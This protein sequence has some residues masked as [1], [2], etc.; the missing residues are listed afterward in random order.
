LIGLART[1]KPTFTGSTLRTR[2][3]VQRQVAEAEAT[4]GAGRAF[5]YETFRESWDAALQSTE[6][7]LDRKSKMQLATSHANV[8]A[9]KAVE[10]VHDAAGASAI[11]N[12]YKFQRYFRDARTMTQ[13]AA[14]SAN[15]YE[16]V[17]ALM[18]GEQSDWPFFAL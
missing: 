9:A 18:L 16:S 10:L 5:L 2:Q 7:T 1:K 3:V 4:L 11:R 17:G 8:C 14:S 12:Q 15:R 13:H 6:I